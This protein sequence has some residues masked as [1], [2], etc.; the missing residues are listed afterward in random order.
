[1]GTGAIT[2]G[3]SGT[4]SFKWQSSY[5]NVNFN[6]ITGAT[7][8][9][10][11]PPAGFT[12]TTHF[13]RITVSTMGSSLGPVQCTSVSNTATIALNNVTPG[14]INGDQSLCPGGNPTIFGNV[15]AGTA[16]NLT[17]EWRSSLNATTFSTILSGQTG[18]TCDLP[19]PVG[20]TTYYRRY[21][22]NLLNNV[23]CSAGSNIITVNILTV[24][25][26]TASNAAVCKGSVVGLTGSPAGGTWS[27]TGVS[28]SNF[29]SAGLAT[30]NYTV[31][32]SIL[33]AN[34]CASSANATVTVNPVPVITGFT[35]TSPV[36][37]GR[38]YT[39]SVAVSG[40][41]YTFSW[42]KPSSWVVEYQSGNTIRLYVPTNNTQYGAVTV[43]VSN[44][45]CTASNGTTTYPAGT[46]CN[47]QFSATISPNPANMEMTLELTSEEE[48]DVPV[49]IYSQVGGLMKRTSI[50]KGS[51]KV[52]I[53]TS[54]LPN[55]IYLVEVKQP[56]GKTEFKRLIVSH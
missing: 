28:G 11:N 50:L 13:Q 35:G 53:D 7:N 31:T 41:G 14:S 25:A 51:G 56:K 26:V 38:S 46:A 20:Q 27:G 30:G 47:Q 34:G 3:G 24:A 39:Y 8:V 33:N 9:A 44:G 45:T 22:K 12:Q 6:P 17:Y 43:T 2:P 37:K 29:N 18:P 16:A 21:A 10:Y 49:A 52:T 1:M 23:T 55:G 4:I 54:G 15:E 5:D 19:G 42:V 40:T 36:C 32:Y 48:A